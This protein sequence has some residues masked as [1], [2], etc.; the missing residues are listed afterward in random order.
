MIPRTFWL[1]LALLGLLLTA[2]VVPGVFTLDENNYL[3]QIVGL[4]EGRLSVPGTEGLPPSSELLWFDPN[5]AHRDVRETPVVSTAPPLYAFLALPAAL[6]GW[7]GLVFL[8]IL[9]YLAATALVFLYARRY[10][11]EPS[12]PWIAAGAFALGS[13]T[14][15]YAQ[16]MWPQ[17]VSLALTTGAV[18]LAARVRDGAAVGW[19]FA[20]GL[21]GGLATGVRYQNIFFAGCVGLGIFL[22]TRRRFRASFGYGAGCLV[23][24]A[25]LS[26]LNRLRLGFWNPVSKGAGYV[27]TG[28]ASEDGRFLADFFTMAW[29]RI[30]DYSTRP[31]MPGSEH[32]SYLIPDPL[33]GAYLLGPTL[34]KAWLQSAPWIGLA[35]LVC[36]WVW[37]PWSRR[38]D[39]GL[40]R[41]LRALSLVIWP[42]LAMFSASGLL[43]TD[44][45]GFNQRYFLELVPLAAVAFAFAVD[46][47]VKTGDLRRLGPAGSLIGFGLAA[48]LLGWFDPSDVVRQRWLLYA[49]LALAGLLVAAWGVQR[50]VPRLRGMVVAAAAACLAWGFVLHLGSDLQTSR[51]L[52]QTNL[53]KTRALAQAIPRDAPNGSALI[54]FWGNKDA[55]GPLLLDRDLVI[56]DV[57]NDRGASARDLVDALLTRGR[58]VFLLA[59]GFPP[60]GVQVL[61]A[62][63]QH[64]VVTTDPMTLLEIRPRDDPGR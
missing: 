4:W 49:P 9:G 55:A 36:L 11:A 23:P 14:I 54:A 63:R 6:L 15:E 40:R 22:W 46:G 38:R 48:S 51:V 29:A 37:G 24:L 5:G 61:L 31:P 58:R 62:G 10:A 2:T 34:K 45:F 30:A 18:Y 26:G 35:L 52:R 59:T 16:G 7:R 20:A 1:A 39:P 56:L 47:L 41:E 42:T 8:N 27:P 19:A 3:V 21:L 43:R 12:T 25:A 33:T 60:H 64:R 50:H 57:R 53:E 17:M 28:Q 44:G 13:Y 32:D